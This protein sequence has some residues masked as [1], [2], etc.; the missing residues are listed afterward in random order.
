M[1]GKKIKPGTM[2]HDFIQVKDLILFSLK[3]KFIQKAIES[4]PT[5]SQV[6]VTVR[7]R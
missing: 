7:R 6:S 1:M 3:N 4:L 5:G 2:A